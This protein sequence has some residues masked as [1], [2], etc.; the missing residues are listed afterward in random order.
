VKI[1]W[2]TYSHCWVNTGLYCFVLHILLFGSSLFQETALKS[3]NIWHVHREYITAVIVNELIPVQE[4][5]ARMRP[6]LHKLDSFRNIS[7][8]LPTQ[9]GPV[10]QSMHKGETTRKT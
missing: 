9:E 7:Q 5:V 8:C 10:R 1:F 4:K 3:I 2:G 6:A